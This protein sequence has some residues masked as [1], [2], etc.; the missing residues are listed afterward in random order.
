MGQKIMFINHTWAQG[1]TTC[2]S[3]SSLNENIVLEFICVK[4]VVFD[5]FVTKMQYFHVFW[6]TPVRLLTTCQ[7]APD[8]Q[9]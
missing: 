8:E 1:I 5:V 3:G 9:D 7:M 4:N 6:P 2:N